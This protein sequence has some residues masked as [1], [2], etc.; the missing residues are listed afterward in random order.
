HKKGAREYYDRLVQLVSEL[1]LR[2]AVTFIGS[3]PSQQIPSTYQTHDIL[4]SCTHMQ[5]WGIAAFE[6]MATGQLVILS[7]TTGASEVLTDRENVLI[8]EPLS[9][10]SIRDSVKELFTDVSLCQKLSEQGARFVREKIT[11]DK[12]AEAMLEL[13]KQPRKKEHHKKEVG[14]IAARRKIYYK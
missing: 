12:Y 10:T 3:V 6:A 7:R 8:A 1:G 2:E 9:P 13:F 5:T 11:W 14:E 4:I